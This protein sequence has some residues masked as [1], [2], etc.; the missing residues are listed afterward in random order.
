MT[1]VNLI[2]GEYT[3]L[4][5]MQRAVK[6]FLCYFSVLLLL[7]VGARIALGVAYNYESARAEKL[8][9]GEILMEEE[10]RQLNQLNARKEDLQRRLK[11]LELL[12]GGPP[13]KQMF[14]AIDKAINDSVWVTKLNF[15]RAREEEETDKAR[16]TGYFVVVPKG[17]KDV[18]EERPWLNSSHLKINGMA[19]SHSA[20]AGFVQ[21]LVANPEIKKVQVQNTRSR[22]YLE[23][24]V[25]EFELAAVTIAND[26]ER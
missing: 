7:G 6:R 19:V 9:S 12:R 18:Y 13:A 20:L 8:K 11:M 2:P 21:L 1:D 22:K 24:S 23:T 3:R 26:S 16:A 4:Q 15:S 17:G 10:K 25:I 14:I 5:N